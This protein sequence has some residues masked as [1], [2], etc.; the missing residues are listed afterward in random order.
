[1]A[2]HD[3]A[4]LCGQRLY[5]LPQG[6]A[7]IREGELGPMRPRRLR[8]A[9]C[10]RSIVGNAQDQA[11][12]A[13]HQPRGFRHNVLFTAGNRP[14]ASYGI[15]F[16]VPQGGG[17]APSPRLPSG[18]LRESP[19]KTGVNALLSAMGYGEGRGEGAFPQAQTRGGAPD[20][21]PSLPSPPSG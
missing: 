5:P 3:P 12:L 18:R 13:R 11:A 6:V 20:P 16:Q 19:A 17:A 1:M 21:P 10:D 2:D 15:G 7:L 8:D 4:G 9:P 14:A